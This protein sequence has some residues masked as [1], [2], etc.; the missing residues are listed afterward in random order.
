[1]SVFRLQ[2]NTPEVYT[3]TS[4]D[5]QLIERLYDCVINGIRFDV[6]S[7]LNIVDT[8][9]IDSKLLSLLQTKIGFFTQN[10]ITDDDLRYILK[11]FPVIV[12]NKGSLK[13]IEGAVNVFLKLKH[14]NTNVYIKIFNKQGQYPYIVQIGLNMPYM[15]TALLDEILKYVLPTG[16]VVSYMFNNNEFGTANTVMEIKMGANIVIVKDS[17]SSI[18]RG[19]YIAYIN[20]VEDRL[21]GSVGETQSALPYDSTYMGVVENVSDLPEYEDD[22]EK[23]A[24]E[25]YILRNGKPW[26]SGFSL[27]SYMYMYIEDSS[28]YGWKLMNSSADTSFDVLRKSVYGYYNE[29]NFYETMTYEYSENDAYAQ[30]NGI[31]ITDDSTPDNAVIEVF[32]HGL[33]YSPSI[34]ILWYPDENTW[35]GI[36]KNLY[37]VEIDGNDPNEEVNTIIPKIDMVVYRRGNTYSTEALWKSVIMNNSYMWLEVGQNE[38][39]E[40][41]V[42]SDVIIEGDPDK[43]KILYAKDNC[44][45]NKENDSWYLETDTW[46]KRNL[47]QSSVEIL[48]NPN[49][50]A[51]I[52]PNENVRVYNNDYTWICDGKQYSD[53]ITPQTDALYIDYDTNNGYRYNSEQSKFEQV[54]FFIKANNVYEISADELEM[55]IEQGVIK[56]AFKD[57]TTIFTDNF[58]SIFLL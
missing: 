20:K 51:K 13:G 1:M 41:K 21:I 48:G 47:V 19:S 33:L 57:E 9:S 40:L 15:D 37:G 32:P 42:H 22:Y 11:A 50:G 3:N 16:Y 18:V 28:S 7:I 8:N 24:G 34:G 39:D 55:L 31:S 12:K 54:I 29:N 25:T 58:D 36:D 27:S 17:A 26:D 4:R 46:I 5:F 14:V 6:D 30:K 49:T 23:H 35:E 52:L 44:V 10:D 2:E 43:C 53:E 56:P 45:F 38:I